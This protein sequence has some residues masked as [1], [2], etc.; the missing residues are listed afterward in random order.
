[1]AAKV[2]SRQAAQAIKMETNRC[3]RASVYNVRTHLTGVT[4]TRK[5]ASARKASARLCRKMA[6][7]GHANTVRATMPDRASTNSVKAVTNHVRA[8]ISPVRVVTGHTSTPRIMAMAATSPVKT[9]T[10]SVRQQAIGLVSTITAK[11][12]TNLERAATSRDKVATNP[13]RA[14]TTTVKGA[15]TVVATS[16]RTVTKTVRAATNSVADTVRTRLTMTPTQSIA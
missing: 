11:A 9:S 16:V 13:V 10:D 8:A 14:A 7:S 4:T 6:P 15:S 12:V 1:V 2:T 3:V 5:G